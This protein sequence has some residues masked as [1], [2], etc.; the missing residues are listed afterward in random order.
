M[1]ILLFFLSNLV[2]AQYGGVLSYP[3]A[4]TVAI[5]SQA[6]VTSTGVY[7]ILANPANL[8]LQGTTIEIS[9]VLPIPS[10]NAVSGNDFMTFSD[11]EYYFGGVKDE[12]GNIIGRY[13][14]PSE[15]EIL[16]SKF[17]EG[18]R[19]QTSAA[20]NLFSISLSAGK[21][22]GNFGFSIN[23][24]LGQRTGLPKDLIDLFLNGNRVGRTYYL[25][26]LVLSTSYLREYNL[27]YARDFS[28]LLNNIFDSFSAGV[29]L[30][31]V[32]GYAYTEIETIGTTIKTLEDHSILI[33]NNLA[34]NIAVSQDFGIQWDFD[35]VK[36]IQNISPFLNPAGVGFGINFGFAT[37]L[38]SIWTFGLSITD[39][40]SVSWDNNPVSYKSSSSFLIS[41]V[42]DS[43][44]TDSIEA[45]LK[46]IGSYSD[47]FTS[48]L[49]TVLRLGA[50]FRLDR[51]LNGNF[52]GK[53]LLVVGYNQGFNNSLNNTTSPLLSLGFEWKPID[54]FPI[55]SGFTFGGFTGFA[56]SLGLGIDAEVVEFNFASADIISA[57]KGND[58]KVVQFTI[59]SRW[60]F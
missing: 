54:L 37:E 20:I 27:S 6:A 31:L 39:I 15:K 16:L 24:V 49:P 9:T 17:N 38:D 33:E 8:A 30:K 28:P 51:F 3:D 60:K 45:A 32:H 2:M 44:L 29:T 21:D 40:G 5:G 57:F 10:I 26:D 46:P 13:L 42:T 1:Y 52:P 35:D 47:G 19:I 25:N 23:D 34:A 4:R 41:D 58:T 36:N 12:N 43:T 48:S 14:D 55:R 7:A 11:I 22:I 50:S 18:N 56:W 59:G 53:M